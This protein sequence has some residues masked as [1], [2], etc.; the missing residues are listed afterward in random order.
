MEIDE[1][2]TIAEE[3][4]KSFFAE[5]DPR[6]LMSRTSSDIVGDDE[7]SITW[8]IKRGN[9]KI[10]SVGVYKYKDSNDVDVMYALKGISEGEELEAAEEI[11]RKINA[12]LAGG[13][14]QGGRRHS[15]K[16]GRSIRRHRSHSCKR[17]RNNKRKTQR[18]RF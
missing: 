2:E 12:R 10:G 3:E 7:F 18:R 6:V 4:F 8:D 15:G 14:Q 5:K 1:F 13:Q 9:D 16:R 17:S 11:K